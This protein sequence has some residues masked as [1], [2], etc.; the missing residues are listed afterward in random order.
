LRES[1]LGSVLELFQ[2]SLGWMTDEH[3]AAFFA[4][5][6]R[7]N[8]FGPSPGWVAVDGDRIAGV[9]L[10]MPW[11]F[12]HDG[13]VVR[14]VRAVD[15]ATAAPYRGA[16]VF[17]RLTLHGL[18]E[19]KAAGVEFVFNT[20][21]DRSRPGYLKMGWQVLGK[22]PVRVR[23]RSVTSIPKLATARTAADLW[24]MPCPAGLDAAEALAD[25]RPLDALLASQPKGGGLR[26]RRSPQFLQWRYGGF[27][28]LAYR[29]LLA[30]RDVEG[31]FAVFRLRRRGGAIEA[32]VGDVLAPHGDAR[33]LRH[34][35]RGVVEESRADY[36]V[37]LGAQ[38]FTRDG[39]LPVPGAGPVITWRAVC[40]A[41]PVALPRWCLSLGDVELF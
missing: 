10:F 2:T 31:G 41:M 14:A 19:L 25:P 15:T 38:G 13:R 3:H 22:L 23:P 6:H 24:S 18:E 27:P 36:A 29:V 1:N 28:P 37:C 20:P 5:K 17:S 26:T 33:V 11:E 8:P 12:E 4:W 34:L 39:Y 40:S 7:S 9:R 35:V 21:N 30:G 32:V 16:G